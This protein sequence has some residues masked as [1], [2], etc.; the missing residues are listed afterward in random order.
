MEAPVQLQLVHWK[1]SNFAEPG[2]MQS[3]LWISALHSFIHS[4]I[5]G[6]TE[7]ATKPTGWE[8]VFLMA[9]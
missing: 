6:I 1:V 4:N 5:P 3:C 7:L 8:V 9:C 2:R